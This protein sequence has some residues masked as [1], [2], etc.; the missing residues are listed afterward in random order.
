MNLRKGYSTLRGDKVRSLSEAFIANFLFREKIEYEY[1]RPLSRRA[2]SLIPDFYLKEYNTYVEFFGKLDT[3]E[4]KERFERKI[5]HYK[6]NGVRFMSLLPEDLPN[7]DSIFFLKLDAMPKV[8]RNFC[9][10]CGEKTKNSASFCDKC[11]S[12]LAGL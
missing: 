12:S 10:V 11:G 1:E 4:Y 8:A 7:L 3:P 6:E 9:S 2:R 5:R